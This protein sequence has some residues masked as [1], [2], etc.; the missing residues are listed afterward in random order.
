MSNILYNKIYNR[1]II[2]LNHKDA[3]FTF[4]IKIVYSI[5]ELIIK[6]YFIEDDVLHTNEYKNILSLLS[7]NYLHFTEDN[8]IDCNE[9][10]KTYYQSHLKRLYDEICNSVNVLNQN[11]INFIIFGNYI[12]NKI[13]IN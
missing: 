10:L 4:N 7:K 9:M 3:N 5:I 13:K 8:Y 12:A 6:N 11:K 1:E 2:I